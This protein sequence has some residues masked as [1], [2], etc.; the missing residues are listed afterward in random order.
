[1]RRLTLLYKRA[2]NG[3]G[4]SHTTSGV[5]TTSWTS[6]K[7]HK[8][9]K[10]N[11][12]IRTDHQ[13]MPNDLTATDTYC[14][15]LMVPLLQA[16]GLLQNAVKTNRVPHYQPATACIL[17]SVRTVLSEVGCLARDAPYLK[18]HPALARERKLILSGLASLVSRAKKF[19]AEGLDVQSRESLEDDMVRQAGQLFSLVRGFLVIA[20][21]SGLNVQPLSKSASTDSG[22]RWGSQEDTLVRS[23]DGANP[24]LD[25]GMAW[26]TKGTTNGIIERPRNRFREPTV[27]PKA[28]M[29]ARSM[30]DLRSRV[31]EEQD[32]NVPV[33]PISPLHKKQYS[34]VTPRRFASVVG[35]RP[36]QD[37][38]S[39][40]SSGS[41]C[42]SG[43]SIGT[44]PTPMFP[45]GPSTTPT[46]MEALR[47][48]HD[49]YLS[50]I[51]AF[52]GH[53]HSHSRASH[54]SST[55]HMYDLVREIVEMVCKLLTIVEAVLRH[56][57][58]P[59]Q[60][61][62]DLRIAKDGLYSVTSTLADSVRMLTTT[63]DPDVSEEE[64]KQTLLRSATNA[65]KAG[66]DCVTAVKKCLQR[67]K[68]ERP[69]VIDLPGV[70]E[71]DPA[72]YTPSKFSHHVSMKPQLRDA[73]SM[74]ALRELYRAN[75]LEGDEEE[76]LTIGAQTMSYKDRKSVV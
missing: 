61:A 66:S 30:G 56:P 36:A 60:K 63:P 23:D 26:E 44:P 48:T 6:N 58:I 53:A 24:F 71:V 38:V 1:M 18:E 10:S 33:L 16:I 47:H 68:G 52:I 45:T 19:S 50:T 20:V 5:S 43:D 28:A 35:H 40:A 55:G 59:L 41:S 37:S 4:H 17:S 74:H 76:E 3:L 64:E 8:S 73:S 46:V 39:S 51:A 65:L 25:D 57:D 13:P 31:R 9:N 49:N 7:S 34:A 69:L 72:S 29:R 15:P 22:G 12:F 42:S 54:A 2:R 32:E 70:G 21:Q 62:Q 27:T 75:G 11:T 67:S 14:P